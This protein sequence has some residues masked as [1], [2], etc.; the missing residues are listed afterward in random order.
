MNYSIKINNQINLGTYLF[1][2][3][4]YENT[5]FFISAQGISNK[6]QIYITNLITFLICIHIKLFKKKLLP[7]QILTKKI[8]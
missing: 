7:T 1:N 2:L 6:F 4:Y 5:T 8:F 3:N